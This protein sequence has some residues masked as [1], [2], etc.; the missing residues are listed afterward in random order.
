MG[1]GRVG[2]ELCVLYCPTGQG[3]LLSVTCWNHFRSCG[4]DIRKFNS[5]ILNFFLLMYQLIMEVEVSIYPQKPLSWYRVQQKEVYSCEYVKQSL[6]LYYLLITVLFSTQT[7][8]NL[9]LPYCTFSLSFVCAI[10][11]GLTQPCQTLGT[12]HSSLTPITDSA[13]NNFLLLAGTGTLPLTRKSL[14]GLWCSKVNHE[15]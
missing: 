11:L 12:H 10:P 13:L 15:R 7:T 9:L 5:D 8:V 6:F 4:K 14:T 2:E 1:F 3:G